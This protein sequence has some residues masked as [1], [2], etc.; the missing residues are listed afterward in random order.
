MMIEFFWDE[1]KNKANQKKH[2]V[3]FEEAQSVFADEK[4]RLLHDVDHSAEEDR[5]ILLGISIKLKLLVVCHCY[6]EKDHLIRIISARK[7]TL[8]EQKQYEEFL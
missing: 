2:G 8:K 1:A 5:F 6:R 4:A 3:S 7:A